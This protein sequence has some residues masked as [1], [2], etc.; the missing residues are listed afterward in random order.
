MEIKLRFFSDIDIVLSFNLLFQQKKDGH[1]CDRQYDKRGKL[2]VW[3]VAD[4]QSSILSDGFVE[5]LIGLQ[6]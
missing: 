2:K 6:R 5:Y 3:E 1:P 4:S